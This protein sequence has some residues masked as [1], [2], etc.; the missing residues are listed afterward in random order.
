MSIIDLN[1]KALPDGA[2]INGVANFYRATKP[3]TRVDGSA[4][5]IGDRW[6][7]PSTG[8]DWFWN[9]TYFLSTQLFYTSNFSVATVSSSTNI[10]ANWGNLAASLDGSRIIQAPFKPKP[11]GVASSIFFENISWFGNIAAAGTI[12]ASNYWDLNWIIS[13]RRMNPIETIV[14]SF[15][16]PEKVYGAFNIFEATKTNIVHTFTDTTANNATGGGD[17]ING[18]CIKVGSPPNLINQTLKGTFRSISP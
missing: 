17:F 6:F 16:I 11:F 18:S 10:I 14:A 7:N 4:L 13:S 8:E 3:L 1:S 12:D 5:V 9:G 2:L 15:K